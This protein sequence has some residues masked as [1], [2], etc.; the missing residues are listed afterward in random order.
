MKSP[1]II[2]LLILLLF[3]A[4]LCRLSAQTENYL[5]INP[6]ETRQ[7]Q[8]GFGASLAFYE[9][10]LN[11]HPKKSEIYELIFGEL[12]L[13][14]LR[15]RNAYGYDPQMVGRVKEYMVAAEKSLGHPIELLSTS[16]GP[17]DSLKNTGDRKNGGSLRYTLEDGIVKFDYPGFASWWKGSLE[18]YAAHGILP[19]YIS[20]QNEPGFTA[21]WESC[22]LTPR[23]SITAT[24][25]TAGYDK[26]LDAV[27]DS[28]ATLPKSPKILGPETVG[29]GYNNV[30]KYVNALDLSRLD[31][32]AHHLYHGV[33]ENDPWSST[34]FKELGNFHP[35]VPHFQTEYS[36]GDWFSLAGLIYMSYHEEEVVSYLYWD[37]IWGDK[38]G[39][40]TVE[41]PWNSDRWTDPQKGYI[42]NREYYAFKQ[43]SAF[44]HPGWKRIVSPV[45]EED[46]KILTFISPGMDSMSCV[47]I[48]RSKTSAQ[49]LNINIEGYRISASAMYRTSQDE[50]CILLGE[51]KDSIL[52]AN[53]Y[54]ITTVA[55]EIESYDPVEDVEAPSIPQNLQSADISDQSFTLSWEE[56]TDNIGVK[57]YGI[58]MDGDS[59]GTSTSTEFTF[60]GLV[61]GRDYAVSVNAVDDAGNKS[62]FSDT[63]LVS[64]LIIDRDPPLLEATDSIY[65]EGMVEAVSSEDGVIY[66]VT[67]G[68]AAS[69][70]EIRT[71]SL[72]SSV[73]EGEMPVSFMLSGLENG[74]Y[75]LY[76]R[77]TVSN[78][79]E[80]S[81]VT[82]YGVGIKQ[83]QVIDYR[84]YPN[85]MDQWVTIEFSLEKGASVWLVLYDS[86]G[87]EVRR[88]S[89]ENLVPGRQNLSFHRKN[90]A[91]GLYLLKME[92]A[93]GTLFTDRLLLGH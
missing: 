12:S 16:W 87:R 9:G 82:V 71:A 88:E 24:D 92:T 26:A 50:E 37:L 68:T 14:I 65:Q 46:L 76:A 63:L 20:I 42:I 64:T 18:E 62:D 1:T 2:R 41:F 4:P 66:L 25:T 43:F 33:D 85:P 61:P 44:I 13:D 79:S 11:A 32:M 29:I 35:E 7:S 34:K 83:A 15:V 70:E 67:G 8:T 53:P 75:W 56:S 91:G 27:Y 90:L 54:S 55:M 47:V 6:A 17:A 51:L 38:G 30:Q 59:A 40:L 74:E 36:R 3:I 52:L 73:V 93:E 78:L 31:G 49:H 58:F 84:I 10:W 19:D 57:Y 45:S 89:A 72:D 86:R 60:G 81:I 23:E 48:N 69:L 5:S 21:T 28:L 22:V 80:P 77:D 39:L